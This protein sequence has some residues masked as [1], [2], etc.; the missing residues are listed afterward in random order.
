MVPCLN[1]VTSTYLPRQSGEFQEHDH[2]NNAVR[3]KELLET[4]GLSQHVAV[5][6][7]ISGHILDLVITRSIDD[8]ILGPISTSLPLSDHLI[9]ECFVYF[10]SPLLSKKSVSFRKLKDID[11]DTFKSDILSSTL[12]SEMSWNDLDDLLKHYSSA[13]SEILDKHAPLK[14]KTLAARGKI[15]WFST[16]IKACSS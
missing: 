12:G 9:V 16:T 3:F 14:T 1:C 8:L 4:F 10:P 2:S 13:L 11:I 15:P 5:S 7:H 6:T